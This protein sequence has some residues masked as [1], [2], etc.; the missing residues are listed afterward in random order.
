MAMTT[1]ILCPCPFCGSHN[2]RFDGGMLA[3][4][5][6]W[7]MCIDCYAKGP[8]GMGEKE[9]LDCWNRRAEK[10]EHAHSTTNL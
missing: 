8:F 2:L 10:T 3:I 9:A 7:I 6:D 5:G 1:K 4:D